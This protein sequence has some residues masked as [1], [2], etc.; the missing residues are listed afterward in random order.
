MASPEPFTISVPPDKI[1]SLKT[2]L[3][4]AQ[5][6]DELEG[7]ISPCV[8]CSSVMIKD[9]HEFVKMSFVVNNDSCS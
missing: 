5:F 8:F 3:S 2:K 9:L 6:P 7:M 4:L 1:D